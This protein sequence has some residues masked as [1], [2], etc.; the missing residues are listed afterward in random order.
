MVH[1]GTVV[2]FIQEFTGEYKSWLPHQHLDRLIKNNKRL[3]N[4]HVQRTEC[5]E[6]LQRTEA[7]V[8]KAKT[9]QSVADYA[10]QPSLAREFTPT[11][12]NK[13]KMK[14]EKKRRKKSGTRRSHCINSD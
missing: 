8:M 14:R 7:E 10:A 11:C 1:I 6:A 5:S 3:L 9:L 4:D 12:Q 13:Q 2:E